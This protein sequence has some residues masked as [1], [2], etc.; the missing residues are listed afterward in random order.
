MCQRI[1]VSIGSEVLMSRTPATTRDDGPSPK[2]DPGLGKGDQEAVDE[3]AAESFPA[4]DAP[5]F[6]GAAGSPSQESPPRI[7]VPPPTRLH[8][9]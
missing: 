7:V 4:S 3:A 5:A 9:K 6:T 8:P 2:C 1:E